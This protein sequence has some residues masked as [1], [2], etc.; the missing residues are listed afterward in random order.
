MSMIYCAD[1]DEHVDTDVDVETH[2]FC[3]DT[4]G[5]RFT[6][7]TSYMGEVIADDSGE[8]CGNQLRF[9]TEQEAEWYVKD[10]SMRWLAV[11]DTR[12]VPSDDPVTDEI[13]RSESGVL[14]QRSV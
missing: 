11:R 1:H 9:A 8:W 3:H 14:L 5:V 2:R 4:S 10:L 13:S 7:P 6:E 12:V